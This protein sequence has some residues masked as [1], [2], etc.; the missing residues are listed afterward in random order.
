MTVGGLY[1]L[2]V[3]LALLAIF[4]TGRRLSTL[5][6]ARN[7]L[8]LTAH[9][10]LSLCVAALLVVTALRVN[11]ASGLAPLDWVVVTA[12]VALWIATAASGGAIS[13]REAAGRRIR[14]AHRVTAIL[15]AFACAAA[16]YVLLVQI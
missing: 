11:G 5:K 4:V 6:K 7:T 15:T 2:G 8:L 16:L 12:A 13:A 9:K 3:G 1:V 14:I 10:I